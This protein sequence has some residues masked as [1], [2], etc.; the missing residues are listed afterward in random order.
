MTVRREIW[1]AGFGL[2]ALAV[3]A[4]LPRLAAAGG[5]LL[6]GAGAVST[7]RAGAAVASADDGEALVLNPAGIAKATGTTITL[8]AAIFSYSMEFQRRGSYDAVSGES[9]PYAMQPF[10]AVKND[11]S[12]PLGIGS[13]QPVPLFTV[14]SD[15]GGRVPGLHVGAGVYI[16]SAYPFRDLC[17]ELPAGAGCQKYQF[18]DNPNIPPPPTRYDVMKQ[19]AVILLPSLA[20]AYRIRPELDVGVRVSVGYASLKST[21]AVWG[22]ATANYEEDIKKDGLINADVSDS[23]VFGFGLGATYRPTPNLELAANYTSELDIYAKGTAT[24][25]LGP[26]AGIPGLA[27]T[28]GPGDGD[29]CAPG[30]T[31]DALKACIGLAIPRS[32]QLAGRYKFLDGAGRL[33]GDVELDLGWENWGKTCSDADFNNGRCVSPTDYRVVINS[34]VFVNG[35]AVL[36]LNDAKLSHGF[37]DS[38]A[39]RAGG[40]YHLPV[41]AA[42]GD[43]SR[44]EVILRGGLGYETAAART[45]WL[46]ADID[47]A[48]RTTITAGAAYRMQHLE[49]SA[50]GG[51]ILEG[52]PPNPNVGGGATPCNPTTADPTCNG[53]MAHQGP[54]PVNPILDP[55]HQT[56]N[57]VNQG[58][59]KSHYVMLM[60]G[61]TT[62]F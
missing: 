39:I 24:S 14:L 61:V 13:L 35:A 36:P 20:A 2:A 25:Q 17:T 3:L 16:P 60:L 9:Y 29:R 54:D 50:G 55:N 12:P 58:D 40:S 11:A 49:I 28:I 10:P 4:A 31:A 19:D 18:G 27:T 46:R 38:Y 37:Q 44:D 23:F 53:S 62:W 57:P 6:P 51:A 33:R 45:G 21:T 42:R 26:S 43:G 8:S 22:T 59:Y 15:L 5:L 30:G 47:G 52:S 7:S 41:G 1:F 32:A 56:L 48:A 34:Q